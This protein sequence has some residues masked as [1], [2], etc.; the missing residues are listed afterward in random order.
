MAIQSFASLH[1]D[2]SLAVVPGTVKLRP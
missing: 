2:K 1:L